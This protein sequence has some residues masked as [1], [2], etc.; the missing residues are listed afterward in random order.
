MYVI[1]AFENKRKYEYK[2]FNKVCKGNLLKIKARNVNQS[3]S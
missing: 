2:T 1:N 3:R